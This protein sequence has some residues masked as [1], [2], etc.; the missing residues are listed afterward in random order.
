MDSLRNQA[1]RW[2]SSFWNSWYLL[3]YNENKM[4]NTNLKCRG[5]HQAEICC[6]VSGCSECFGGDCS[7]KRKENL[8]SRSLLGKVKVR[9]WRAD[10]ALFSFL[11]KVNGYTSIWG[12]F[13]LETETL[14]HTIPD[15]FCP[16]KD[17]VHSTEKTGNSNYSQEL[18]NLQPGKNCCSGLLSPGQQKFPFLAEKQKAKL[19]QKGPQEH[20]HAN[21]SLGKSFGT[22]STIRRIINVGKYLQDHQF[23]H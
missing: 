1:G 13:F 15:Y 5:F 14:N 16:L 7:C 12:F 18:C 20:L 4:C 3:Q 6:S 23:K 8:S 21:K 9:G 19:H 2:F 10:P 17:E 22:S 11:Q